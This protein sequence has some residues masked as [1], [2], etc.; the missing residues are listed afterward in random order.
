ML[1]ITG[2]DNPGT[3]ATENEKNQDASASAG[4]G[5]VGGNFENLSTAAKLAKS[6]K[7]KSTKSKKSDLPKANFAKVNF[8]TDFLISKA[9]K[10]VI[11]L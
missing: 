6:K 4:S 1:Q 5:E 10:V 7:S 8:E 11:H 9:K 3:Q 2:D